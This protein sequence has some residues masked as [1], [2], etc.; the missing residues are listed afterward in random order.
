MRPMRFHINT[1]WGGSESTPTIER[2]RQVLAE[3]DAADNEH[4]DVSLTH[5]SEWCLSAFSSGLLVWENVEDGEPRHMLSVS[6]E[7]VLE[8]WAKLSEGRISEIDCE[9]WAPG[10]GPE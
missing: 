4:P 9:A 5:E 10:Y 2:M 7:K 3:L 8:L 6:R 1:R